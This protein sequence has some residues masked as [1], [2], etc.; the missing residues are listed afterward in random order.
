MTLRPLTLLATLLAVLTLSA[1]DTMAG[2]G[3]DISKA[4]QALTQSA[5]QTQAQQGM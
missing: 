5:Q 3:Q 1:C 4:G 2:A